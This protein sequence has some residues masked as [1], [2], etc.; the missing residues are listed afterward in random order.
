MTTPFFCLLIAVL[1]P[2]V[3]SGVGGYYRTRQFGAL[4]NENPRQQQAALEGVGARIQAAQDN[5]R[6]ALPVF[7][8]AVVVAH[9]AGVDPATASTLSVAFILF[10]VLHA[11]CYAASWATLR[12]VA[13]LAGFACC[14]LLF[15][16]AARV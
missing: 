1:I 10:R 6:E 9:L 8:A 2:Y 13:F 11:V 12:S 7:T 14:L 3:L 5:A 16:Q 15:A 4:D